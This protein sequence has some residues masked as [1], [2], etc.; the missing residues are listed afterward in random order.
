MGR[1]ILKYYAALV[2]LGIIVGNG[3][4]FGTAWTAGARGV[5]DVTKSLKS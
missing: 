4:G 1:Q 3:S 5:A 2:G